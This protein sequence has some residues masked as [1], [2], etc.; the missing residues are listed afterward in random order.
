METAV[1]DKHGAPG[2]R[3]GRTI[4]ITVDGKP[5]QIEQGKYLVSDLKEMF[6]IPAEYELDKVVGKKFV[7]LPD[8]EVIEVH[9]HEMFVSHVRHGGSS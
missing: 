9:P 1:D 3:H 7:P 5:R 2:G 6:G 8:N 4:E